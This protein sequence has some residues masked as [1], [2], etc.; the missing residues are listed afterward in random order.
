MCSEICTTIPLP[1]LGLLLA[2]LN[3]SR[4]HGSALSPFLFNV[5]L[6]TISAHIQDQSPWLM[7]YA[8]NIPH[9]IDESQLML[10]RKVNLWKGTLDNGGLETEYMAC[11]SPDSST[12]H[13][14]PELAVKSEKFRYLGLAT[15]R[16]GLRTMSD[17][18]ALLEALVGCFDEVHTAHDS[19]WSNHR[20]R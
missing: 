18:S 3:P 12:I 15:L 1:W 16:A 17:A 10:E 19:H 20:V 5:V 7:M 2:T 8:N 9:H 14:G 6:D 11:G 13:I 4:L